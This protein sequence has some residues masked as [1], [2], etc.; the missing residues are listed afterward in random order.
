MSEVAQNTPSVHTH[1]LRLWVHFNTPAF[2]GGADQSSEWRTPPFK[3]LLRE[4]WRIVKAAEL[5]WT[6][7]GARPLWETIREAEGRL[8]GHAHLKHKDRHGREKPWQMQSR[9]SIALGRWGS[10]DNRNVPLG[11]GARICHPEAKQGGP[12]CPDGPG[13]LIGSHLYL[14]YGPFQRSPI[15]AGASAELSLSAPSDVQGQ[16]ARALKLAHW[17]G[18]VGGRRSNGWGSISLHSA[19]DGQ[20]LADMSDPAVFED[21][22]RPLTDCLQLDWPHAI[23][24]DDDG[25]LVWRTRELAG[26]WEG[27]LTRL[28]EVKIDI[29][30]KL[31]VAP[32]MQLRHILALPVTHHPVATAPR[33][34]KV[35]RLANQLRFKVHRVMQ[36]G[37][38]GF[39]GLIYHLPHRFPEEL[40]RRLQAGNSP[41]RQGWVRQQEK[42]LWPR[43]HSA[44]NNCPELA[45]IES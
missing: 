25:L 36:T 31:H 7:Q 17:L 45:R 42:S 43:V 4:W 29:R 32:G 8:F 1:E 10:A 9:L 3:N 11:A 39:V 5:G 19:E 24:S 37:E 26:T 28:A 21:V 12:R 35:D 27:A 18:A 38:E 33:Q 40:L 15:G 13:R 14:G 2:M 30:T 22:R 41:G 16:L 6:G 23:G 34:P 20:P 44:L